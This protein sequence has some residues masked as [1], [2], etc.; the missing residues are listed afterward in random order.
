M[1]KIVSIANQKG[2]VGKTTTAVNLAAC[3]A[4]SGKKVLL[5][6]IDPQGNATSGVGCVLSGTQKGIYD[7]IMGQATGEEVIFPT[8]I[9]TMDII[10]SS[11]DLAGA[12]IELVNL[13]AREKRL[14]SVLNP[15]KY[16]YDYI[17]ID[18]PPSLGLLTLNAL[19]VS[20]SVLIPMLCEYYSLQGLSLL[21]K[22][23]KRVKQSFNPSLAVEGI[24]LTMFDG[25]TILTNQVKEQIQKYFKDYLLNT[26][27]PRNI[28]LGEAPSHGKPIVLYANNCKG[29]ESYA[30]LAREVI[31]RSNINQSHFM[32]MDQR[33]S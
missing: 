10:P 24:I 22:T 2:G 14:E 7:L 26:V 20:N 16:K 29:A 25:R 32:A 11:V 18:C 9:D 17:F 30:E 27:I 21:L 4:V 8:D 23:L 33:T 12:E 1:G 15:L 5:I 31:S 13:E 6:D 3:I 28:R 19:S